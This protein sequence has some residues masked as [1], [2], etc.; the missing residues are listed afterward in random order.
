M[1][2]LHRNFGFSS[3]SEIIENYFNL[4]EKLQLSLCIE[5]EN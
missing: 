2:K 5:K 1:L 4:E 3:T